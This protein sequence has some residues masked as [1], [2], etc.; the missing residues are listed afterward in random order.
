MRATIC[1]V[2]SIL[3]LLATVHGALAHDPHPIISPYVTNAPTIDGDLSDWDTSTFIRVTP[4][5]G[6][7]D[8]ESDST[9][10]PNDLSFAFGVANDDQYLYVAVTITDDILV[11]DTNKDPSDKDA[12]AWMDDAVE[13]FID[14]DHSHS[15]D[16]RDP[17]GIEFKTGGE[18][19]IVANGA[20]T[21]KMS[22]VPLTNGD[23]RYWTSAGSYGPPLGEAYQS[24]WDSK[25]KSFVVEARFNYRIMG[26]SVG[27]GSRIG[28]T[29]SAHDDDNG[30]GRDAALYW[31]GIS[32]H[33]WKNEMGWGDL[34]LSQPK[35][36][37]VMKPDT[38]G[39]IK[40]DKK[41]KGSE[42][43]NLQ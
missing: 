15:P 31:K 21:S 11:L 24:P 16:A 22:G 27:P 2:G 12:R 32:P 30:G 10:D 28:F 19:S 14:G 43:L 20:V 1:T 38:F 37:P 6:T 25:T 42:P 9:D 36:T 17:K 34:I 18:F 4:Q 33:C 41:G 5:T 29:V 26:E 7:F 39:R 23:P 13:I 3:W 35:T 8:A 40:A